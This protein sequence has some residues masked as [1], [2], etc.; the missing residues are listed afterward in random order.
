MGHR[1]FF[2]ASLLPALASG[3]LRSGLRGTRLRRLR[4]LRARRLR[5]RLRGLRLAG[6]GIGLGGLRVTF[7][8]VVRLVEAAALEDDRSAAT[9]EACEL[10]FLA[11]RALR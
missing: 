7:L 3:L 11:L 1:C 9:E 2:I 10:V 6:L 8:A 5:L 4:R